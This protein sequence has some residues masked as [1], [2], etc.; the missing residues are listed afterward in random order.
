MSL[1]PWLLMFE[2]WLLKIPSAVGLLGAAPPEDDSSD[3]PPTRRG[4]APLPDWEG[5]GK[6]GSSGGVSSEGGGGGGIDTK[7]WG[8]MLLNLRP[9]PGEWLFS[10]SFSVVGLTENDP[11][12]C[13]RPI[14][15]FFF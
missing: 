10:G 11:L 5:N 14:V 2:N 7:P 8:S 1:S 3:A 12:D 13:R 15:F 4:G 6:G 9:I